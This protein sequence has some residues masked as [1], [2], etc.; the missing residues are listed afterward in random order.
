MP[1][2]KKTVHT[3][4]NLFDQVES[5][6]DFK[7]HAENYCENEQQMKDMVELRRKIKN[8][9]SFILYLNIN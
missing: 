2:K 8:R 6:E 9:V 5:I 3:I 4:L 1:L 7:R